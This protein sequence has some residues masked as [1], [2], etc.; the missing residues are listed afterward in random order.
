MRLAVVCHRFVKGDG[1]SR[2]NYEIVKYALAKGHCVTLIAHE[3][4]PELLESSNATWVKI[5]WSKRFSTLIGN[6]RFAHQSADWIDRH[7]TTFDL[8]HV[9]GWIT[10][11]I[12]DVSTAHFVH[13]A[14]LKSSAH[15][16]HVHK[17][18]YGFYQWVNSSIS[19]LLERRAFAQ[20]QI[21]VAVSQLVRS[22]LIDYGVTENKIRVIPN[23]VDTKEHRPQSIERT[24]LGLPQNK[25]LILFAG[26]IRTPR[27]NLDAVLKVLLNC[28]EFHLAVA[29]DLRNSPYPALASRLG[30]DDRVHFLGYRQ[31]LS[32]L[33]MAADIFFLPSRYEPFGLVVLEALASG[34]PVLITST[35]GCADLINADCGIVIDDPEDIEG[36]THALKQ[37]TSDPVKLKH[38]HEA[39]RLLAEKL[40]WDKMSDQ[41]LSLYEELAR[42]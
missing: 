2:V 42:S 6:L 41:Y 35:V 19:S 3:V 21:V 23:G 37:L 15:T 16:S 12:A 24:S 8:L 14:W 31:D 7:R 5:P 36:L 9:N 13:S 10:N 18:L 30:L 11:T 17:G 26:E 38:M 20:S 27:K 39:A 28:P 22:E 1:T 40:S 4:A 29:G 33:M 32:R 34:L 25:L